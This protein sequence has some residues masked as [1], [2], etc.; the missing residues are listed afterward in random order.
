M[1]F[2]VNCT[3]NFDDFIKDFGIHFSTHV[4]DEVGDEVGSH[5]ACTENEHDWD[6]IPIKIH[7]FPRKSDM[8]H[9]AQSPE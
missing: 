9:V 4:K 2:C 8:T 3:S 7:L 1:D 5:E 6:E